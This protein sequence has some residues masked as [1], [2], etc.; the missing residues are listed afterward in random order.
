M[1]SHFPLG[2]PQWLP[3]DK[4][5]LTMVLVDIMGYEYWLVISYVAQAYLVP[6]KAY[7]TDMTG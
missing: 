4:G 3:T 7:S 6:S 2:L 5:L 1:G